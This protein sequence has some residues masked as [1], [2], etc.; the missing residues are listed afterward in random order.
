MRVLTYWS[1][2]G[3]SCCSTAWTCRRRASRSW[4]S[5]PKSPSSALLRLLYKFTRG[6]RLRVGWLWE[7]YHERAE[8][9]QGTPTQSHIPPSILV[10][11]DHTRVQHS[12]QYSFLNTLVKQL[13]TFVLVQNLTVFPSFWKTMGLAW[14]CRRR[15]SRP[16]TLISQHS[17][18]SIDFGQKIALLRAAQVNGNISSS[19]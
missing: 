19:S 7:G 3:R 4:T 17:H 2:C 1:R 9:A 10:Y 12:F 5:A 6:D 8:D 16:S 13:P 14:T 18:K 15:G 11:E